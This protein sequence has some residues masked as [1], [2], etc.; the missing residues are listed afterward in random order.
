MDATVPDF[1]Y[2]HSGYY[3][4]PACGNELKDLDHIVLAVGYKTFNNQ[5]YTIIRNS[6]S[7]HWGSGGYAYISQQN[8]NC[9]IATAPAFVSV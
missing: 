7:T 8:N 6:W 2:Y 5:R 4:N 9:G 3:Y 1:Y